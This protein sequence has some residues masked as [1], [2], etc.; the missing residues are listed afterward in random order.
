MAVRLMSNDLS[1]PDGRRADKN[2]I[3]AIGGEFKK[4]R[5]LNAYRAGILPWPHEGLPILW[6]CPNPRFVLKPK[7]LI[8]SQSLARAIKRNTFEFKADTNFWSVM[9]ACQEIYRKDQKGTWI[10][11]DMIDGYCSLFNDGFAHSIEA[12]DRGELVGGLYGVSM[13]SMFFGESMFFKK[14]NASKIAFT[15]LVAHLLQWDGF[16]IDC[17]A[18]TKHL[19]NFG[20]HRISRDNFLDLVNGNLA[21]PHRLGPWQLS[22]SATESHRYIREQSKNID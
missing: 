6:F 15:I 12:Y 14:P 8:I 18:P 16:L 20:A 10:T 2:G 1:F 5:L 4:E 21:N 17:Q 3:V 7:N 22:M 11:D 19:E 13:G 9:K